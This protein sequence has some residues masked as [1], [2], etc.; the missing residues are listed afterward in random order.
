MVFCVVTQR[1]TMNQGKGWS[2]KLSLKK[3]S[4][5]K[6]SLCE[7][8]DTVIEK[9]LSFFTVFTRFLASLRALALL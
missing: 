5:R 4:S 1:A 8:F 9:P 7:I 3:I 2:E 6:S